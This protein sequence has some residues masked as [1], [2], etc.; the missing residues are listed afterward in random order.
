MHHGLENLFRCNACHENCNSQVQTRKKKRR[1][2][3][4][5]RRALD[6]D[7]LDQFEHEFQNHTEKIEMICNSI[8]KLLQNPRCENFLW[9]TH[10]KH[11]KY[12][13]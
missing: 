6:N 1:K 8:F 7:I 12:F 5:Q 11:L 9:S 2:R 10:V 4:K 3:P 13:V